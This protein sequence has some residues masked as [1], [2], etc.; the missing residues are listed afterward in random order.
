MQHH[1][2]AITLPPADHD[3]EITSI[4]SDNAGDPRHWLPVYGTCILAVRHERKEVGTFL[5]AVDS[6]EGGGNGA[7]VC[8][9]GGG[10]LRKGCVGE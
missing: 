1:L 3:G 6:G 2:K 5:I 9:S 7:T 4:V 10:S 8:G